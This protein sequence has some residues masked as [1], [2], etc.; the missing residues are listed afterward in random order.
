MENRSRLLL[1]LWDAQGCALRSYYVVKLS[2]VSALS[3]RQ[4]RSLKI[5]LWQFR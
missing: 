3:A 2:G 1:L 5:R 4:D